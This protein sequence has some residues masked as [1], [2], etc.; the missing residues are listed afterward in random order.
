VA[1][2]RDGGSIVVGTTATTEVLR[3]TVL[4]EV[5]LADVEATGPVE[6]VVAAWFCAGAEHA[7]APRTAA[8]ATVAASD[9]ALMQCSNCP[10][11]GSQHVG[12]FRSNLIRHQLFTN[13]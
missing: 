5:E 13:T 1:P 8:I 3:G 11:L 4:D 7:A 2:G 10:A 9:L 6:E 12:G